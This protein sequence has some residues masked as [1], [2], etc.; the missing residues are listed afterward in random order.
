M[1]NVYRLEEQNMLNNFQP[2]H[3]F[4]VIKKWKAPEKTT[5][6]II[7]PKDRNDFQSKRGTIIKIG[8]CENLKAQK[9]PIP[10]IKIGDE[11]LFSAFA[12]A[13]IPMPEGYLIMRLSE[14]LVVLA[15]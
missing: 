8:N 14:I 10:D 11:V 12:G 7:V 9:L 13:E 2:M 4:A 1:S 6:G 15:S 3:D 5:A